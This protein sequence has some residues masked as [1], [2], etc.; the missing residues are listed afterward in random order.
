MHWLENYACFSMRNKKPVIRGHSHCPLNCKSNIK[1]FKMS[2]LV[3]NYSLSHHFFESL[4]QMLFNIPSLFSGNP[5]LYGCDNKLQTYKKA[6]TKYWF[7]FLLVHGL[8][9][10]TNVQTSDV[11]TSFYVHKFLQRMIIINPKI[12]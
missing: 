11:A 1:P 2:H 8:H 12:I 7:F 3:G 4:K 5:V 9:C 10:L 6:T